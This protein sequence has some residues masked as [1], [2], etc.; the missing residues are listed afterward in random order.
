MVLF[1]GDGGAA[2]KPE[3]IGVSPA[4]KVPT[5]TESAPNADKSQEVA[6]KD[7]NVDWNSR[8]KF[9]FPLF[10]HFGHPPAYVEVWWCRTDL[11]ALDAL[12]PAS[13]LLAL[14]DHRLQQGREPAPV[15]RQ[16]TSTDVSA[17]PTASFADLVLGRVKIDI[18]ALWPHGECDAWFVLDSQE[19]ALGLAT[20]H[21]QLHAVIACQ[22]SDSAG[23]RA[24]ASA[25]SPTSA[26]RSHSHPS[27][28][29]AGQPTDLSASSTSTPWLVPLINK[30]NPPPAQFQG[31]FRSIQP[32]IDQRMRLHRGLSNA[33]T[34]LI[35]GSGSSASDGAMRRG[36]NPFA[37]LSATCIGVDGDSAELGSVTF[38]ALSAST[39][40][41]ARVEAGTGSGLESVIKR[42]NRP[43]PHIVW[44]SPRLPLSLIP[45]ALGASALLRLPCELQADVS[46]HL[47]CVFPSPTF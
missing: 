5:P 27:A 23:T 19:Q 1:V 12:L 31:A 14:R 26:S 38:E 11:D 46:L 4:H 22:T 6:A 15:P 41:L 36:S 18:G 42:Y 16:T 44:R 34:G 21:E 45:S 47:V 17:L 32:R 20:G 39:L 2:G 33:N 28:N 43:Q 30:S 8:F 13:A 9:S 25:S 7:R 37:P 40:A 29:P 3:C 35:N 10:D 24:T